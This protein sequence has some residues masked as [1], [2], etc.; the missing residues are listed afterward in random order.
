MSTQIEIKCHNHNRD[1]KKCRF[2][3]SLFTFW[4]FIWPTLISLVRAEIAIPLW[5]RQMSKVIKRFDHEL[6]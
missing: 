5:N 6:T 4:M 3:I 1:I 2:I